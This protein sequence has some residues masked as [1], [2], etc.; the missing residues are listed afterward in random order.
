MDS[1]E[2]LWYY[3]YISQIVCNQQYQMY[4]KKGYFL[5]ERKNKNEQINKKLKQIKKE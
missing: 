4:L 2:T 3:T 1:L 5:K